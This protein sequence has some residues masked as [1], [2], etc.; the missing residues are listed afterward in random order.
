MA[1]ILGTLCGDLVRL[2][3]HF[4]GLSLALAQVGLHGIRSKSKPWLALR[5]LLDWCCVGRGS[6]IRCLCVEAEEQ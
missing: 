6:L 3:C 2:A 4:I 5:L 1:S